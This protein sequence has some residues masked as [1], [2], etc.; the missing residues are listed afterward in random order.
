MGET[1]HHE[2][3]I[4]TY[5]ISQNLEQDCPGLARTMLYLAQHLNSM[6]LQLATD[7][8]KAAFCIMWFRNWGFIKIENLYMLKSPQIPKLTNKQPL[9]PF[10]ANHYAL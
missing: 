1:Y 7:F 6:I 9:T 10:L 3:T 8:R 5:R 4:Y 2:F